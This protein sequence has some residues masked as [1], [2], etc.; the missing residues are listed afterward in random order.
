MT[1]LKIAQLGEPVLRQ[2]SRELTRDELLAPTTQ[3]FIDDLIET[4]HDADGAGLAAPQVFHPV[5]I[6]AIHV[7]GNNPR[8]PYKP[9]IPLTVLVNPV[10]TPVID[11]Q[12]DNEEG[13][14]SVADLRGGVK[15]FVHVRVQ[16]WD[17]N[18][19]PLDFE[20]KGLSAGT[21]QHECDHLDGKV[22]VDRVTDPATFATWKN[23]ERHRKAAFVERA[24]AL[25]ARWGG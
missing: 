10:I 3:T 5:R 24:T 15:R 16:A 21:Y 20:A 23:W 9:P 19:A 12:F 25:V 2:R 4:M 17:R 22:F 14:L 8:Y 13:C 18:G 11:E 1:L 6:C 7:R